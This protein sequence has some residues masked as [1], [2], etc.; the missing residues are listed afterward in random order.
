MS[1]EGGLAAPRYDPL[2]RVP[3]QFLAPAGDDHLG[4][5]AG[6]H[7][8]DALA[9]PRGRAGDEGYPSIQSLTHHHPPT[10]SENINRQ[11][12]KNTKPGTPPGRNKKE[13]LNAPCTRFG[14]LRRTDRNSNPLAT[15]ASW[16]FSF[17]F[18]SGLTLPSGLHRWHLRQTQA[19][20]RIHPP[21]DGEDLARHVRRLI[22]GEVDSD[23]GHV[24]GPP[25][26][27]EALQEC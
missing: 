26:A 8:S 5:L 27:S 11:G 9:D 15:L 24:L 3:A 19:P 10:Q 23:P 4:T 6:E 16:R 1:A 7:L 20:A 13:L 21:I 12:A 22:R 17:F 18:G 14:V 25:N 2:H